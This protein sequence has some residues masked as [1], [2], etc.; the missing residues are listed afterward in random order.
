MSVQPHSRPLK[1]AGVFPAGAGELAQTDYEFL[2]RLVYEHSRIHLGP[3][4]HPLVSGRVA[5]RLRVLNLASY[6]EY[7]RLL[8]SAAGAEELGNLV[9]VISTNHTRF[10]REGQHFDWLR[11]ELLPAW[12]ARQRDGKAFRV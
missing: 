1:P 7:C 8:K 6:H 3:D 9:D 12:R 5:K 10:F 11:S 4:K 2:C